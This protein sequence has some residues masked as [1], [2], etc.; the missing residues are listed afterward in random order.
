MNPFLYRTVYRIHQLMK[1]KNKKNVVKRTLVGCFGL[2]NLGK[3]K[4]YQRRLDSVALFLEVRIQ[5]P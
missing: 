2:R 5:L 3:F 4:K 1:R